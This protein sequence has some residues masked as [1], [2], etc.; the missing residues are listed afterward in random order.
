[1]AHNLTTDLRE[2]KRELPARVTTSRVG[3]ATERRRAAT[4]GREESGAKGAALVEPDE[5]EGFEPRDS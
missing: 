3:G 5:I 1:M 2:R 4:G